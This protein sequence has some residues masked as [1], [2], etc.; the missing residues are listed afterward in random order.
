MS[1]IDFVKDNELAVGSEMILP[2]GNEGRL[3]LSQQMRVK[4]LNSLTQQGTRIPTDGESAKLVL[5]VLNDM[6]KTTLGVMKQKSDDSAAQRD[7]IIAMAMMEMNKRLG[8]RSMLRV[9]DAAT[10]AREVAVDDALLP[11]VLPAPGEMDIGAH[12]ITYR[13]LADRHS[14][15]RPLTIEHK[16]DDE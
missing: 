2:E 16:P 11:E 5:Q 14:R 15:S 1:E 4:L 13:E 9:D 10:R 12:N 8:G 6:D 3:E 7:Q